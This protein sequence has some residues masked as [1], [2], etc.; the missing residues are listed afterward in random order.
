MATGAR[1]VFG[2]ALGCLAFGMLAMATL[3]LLPKSCHFD[4]RY[5]DTRHITIPASR[6]WSRRVKMAVILAK[7]R[8]KPLETRPPSY[9]RDYYTRFGTGGQAD[10]WRDV[11]LGAI[12][13]SQSEVF[14]W[15]TMT[16]DS[17][18]VKNLV[19]P[20]G[21]ASLVR[22]GKEAAT[23]AGVQLSKFDAV[24]V[25]QNWGVDHGAAAGGVVIVD[26]NR[27]LIE[28]TFVS[29]EMGHLFGLPHS[30]GEPGISPCISG[31]GEYCDAWDIMSAMNVFSYTGTFQEVDGR[32][33]PGL[34]VF[35]IKALG[36]L[37][38]P[39]M[40]TIRSN[41]VAETIEL[42][43]LNQPL[44]QGAI[45]AVSIPPY[46][47]EYRHKAGWD[48]G[49]PSDAVLVHLEK[50]GRS[51]LE[52]TAGDAGLHTGDHFTT[53][54]PKIE[55]EVQSIDPDAQRAVVRVSAIKSPAP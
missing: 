21:R 42:A 54:S 38:A 34:N 50:N 49:L 30:F 55:I 41:A 1:I 24:L 10:Y 48:R 33:G 53:D 39:R 27:E 15:Y 4:Y 18:E 3:F 11:T 23:A 17:S 40:R 2:C 19:F 36:G 8:D 46:T 14:G 12:D 37:P 13:L 51:Y 32:S 25:V 5:G 45:Y 9:Y 20:G 22:W 7:F 16:H 31:S 44:Q 28:P 52:R 43:P 29:H 35:G 47:I 6:F 26:Q